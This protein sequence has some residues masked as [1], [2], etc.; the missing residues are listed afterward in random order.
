MVAVKTRD[1][2]R[3]LARPAPGI[4][5]CLVFG[6]DTGLV[7]ERARK[8]ISRAIH[9][10]KDPFQLVRIDGDALAADPLRLA[11]EANTVPLFGGRRA[12]W[13]EAQGK[14]FTSAI[15]PLLALPPHDCT[16]VIEAGDL[17]KDAPLRT[18]CERAKGAAAI[19]CFPDRP[20]DIAR[21]IDAEVRAAGLSIG[22][23]ARDFLVN[24]LGQD[25]LSTRSELEKLVTYA[26]GAGEITLNHVEAVVCD[27]SNLIVLEA[28]SNAFQ[29]NRKALDA[30]LKHV[31]AGASG[32]QA[33]LAVA[34]RYAL[35]LHRAQ[36]G[37]EEMTGPRR[38]GLGFPGFR[39][40]EAFDQH[41]RAFSRGELTQA[42]DAVARAI[43][44]SRREPKLGPSL[45]A[46]ALWAIASAARQ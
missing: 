10:L 8:I 35:D 24:Q 12:I 23:D 41:L 16:V 18:L 27:A 17:R 44:H 25:R 6:T 45:A 13:I 26:H 20:E 39:K 5:L 1:A 36:S 33:L 7:N 30:S 31:F 19:Q 9:D 2:D 14:T 37:M 34:L 38:E 11:D 15:E 28:V 29:G 21:L 22:L 3:F 40:T 43:A 4:F 46:R 42:I 32:Y